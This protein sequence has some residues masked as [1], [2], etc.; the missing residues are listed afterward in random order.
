MQATSQKPEGL[1]SGAAIRSYD[2]IATDRFASISKKYDNV[3]IEL[4]YQITDVAKDIAKKYGS[5]NRLP[6]QRRHERNRH[7]GDEALG[8]SVRNQVLHRKFTAAPPAGRIQP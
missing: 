1:D 7:S 6:K 8:R 3:F 2:D 4:A 5:P